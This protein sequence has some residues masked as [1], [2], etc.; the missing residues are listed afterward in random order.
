M[1]FSFYSLLFTCCLLFFQP[2]AFFQHPPITN[3]F[4]II[5]CKFRML[6][7]NLFKGK[8]HPSNTLANKV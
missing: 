6:K 1:I 4:I 3:I 2:A 5:S 8:K 7:I